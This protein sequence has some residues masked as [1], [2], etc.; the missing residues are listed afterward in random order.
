MCS[1]KDVADAVY[2][3]NDSDDSYKCDESSSSGDDSLDEGDDVDESAM[4]SDFSG[5]ESF[6]IELYLN[7]K[8]NRKD[9]KR[10][11]KEANKTHD[12]VQKPDATSKYV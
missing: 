1:Y 4:N 10:R 3:H 9:K 2:D 12:N 7:E 11:E 6:D 5:D 8:R